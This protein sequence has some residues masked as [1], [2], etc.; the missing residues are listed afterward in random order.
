MNPRHP[1]IEFAV[2]FN[3]FCRISYCS[4]SSFFVSFFIRAFTCWRFWTRFFRIFGRRPFVVVLWSGSS[5]ISLVSV[6]EGF[7]SSAILAFS[8]SC[9]AVFGSK[10]WDG[11][12]RTV[13]KQRLY[14]YA[15]R[16]FGFGLRVRWLTWIIEGYKELKSSRIIIVS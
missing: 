13:V 10:Y 11:L 12:R 1:Y 9:A 8:S 5:G 14:S 15:E 2:S 3:A 7:R 6:L 16:E 4:N